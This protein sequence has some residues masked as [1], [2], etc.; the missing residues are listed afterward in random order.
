MTRADLA[1]LIA[2]VEAATAEEQSSILMDVGRALA[3]APPANTT[4]EAWGR[5]WA[6][7]RNWVHDK[8]FLDAAMT[9]VPEG[10]RWGAGN[11]LATD[12]FGAAC[13]ANDEGPISRATCVTPA[14]ALVAA[15]LRA[16]LA[17]MGDDA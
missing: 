11:T 8:A 6:Q 9:L 7:F 15:A 17:Q 13:W 3:N 14:L 2:R 16:R 12:R 10:H 4:L 1:A 5:R